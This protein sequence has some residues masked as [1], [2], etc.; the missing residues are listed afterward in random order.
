[1]I[2]NIELPAPPPGSHK[3]AS[4]KVG[5]ETQWIA[6]IQVGV[7]TLHTLFSIGVMWYDAV[8]CGMCGAV[9]L[10]HYSSQLQSTAT[11]CCR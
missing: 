5:V 9:V 7:E 6:S 1:M 4:G 11:L 3:T 10:S 8:S 2:V